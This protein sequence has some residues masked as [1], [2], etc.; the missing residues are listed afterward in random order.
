[1]QTPLICLDEEKDI[2]WRETIHSPFSMLLEH[3]RFFV[4]DSFS[5]KMSQKSMEI[6]WYLFWP[7]FQFVSQSAA[8]ERGIP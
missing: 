8:F 6:K 2:K 5:T 7:V 4:A 1:L 3:C